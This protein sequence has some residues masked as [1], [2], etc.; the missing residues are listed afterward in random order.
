MGDNK[1][2]KTLSQ[3]KKSD[4]L[5]YCKSRNY[6]YKDVTIIITFDRYNTKYVY[7]SKEIAI[8]GFAY[9]ISELKNNIKYEYNNVIQN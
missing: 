9:S 8:S 6:K 5:F 2:M 1:T 4:F 3:I 7:T